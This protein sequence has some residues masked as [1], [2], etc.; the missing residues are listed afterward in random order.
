[1]TSVN[2]S[3]IGATPKGSDTNIV[4]L[5]KKANSIIFKYSLIASLTNLL[6]LVPGSKVIV[7]ILGDTIAQYK[8]LSDLA[9]NYK[10]DKD[11]FD[12]AKIIAIAADNFLGKKLSGWAV[13][14]IPFVGN[15]ASTLIDFAYTYAMGMV[16]KHLFRDSFIN[17][18]PVDYSTIPDICIR[19]W[20]EAWEYV[21]NNWKGILG[22]QK[23]VLERYDVDLKKLADE[24]TQSNI[25]KDQVMI[26][27]MEVLKN[28]YQELKL[29]R[30]TTEEFFESL[31]EIEN[32]IGTPSIELIKTQIMIA[33]QN[34]ESI[35]PDLLSLLELL[36]E[37]FEKLIKGLLPPHWENK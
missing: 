14:F 10:M 13:S 34:N 11:N 32:E 36:E 3:D 19:V 8:M 9:L 30:I 5:D 25:Q 28:I 31:K 12:T 15:L 21:T 7:D 4:E 22:A 16:F 26:K 27:N 2:S 37:D 20:K 1:M 33:K 17:K 18:T 6:T 29:S 35:D 24:I 23:L